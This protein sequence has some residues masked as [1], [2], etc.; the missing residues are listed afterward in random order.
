[1]LCSEL[2]QGLFKLV[3]LNLVVADALCILF[4]LLLHAHLQHLE[5]A[6]PFDR[7]TGTAGL[8]PGST[9]LAPTVGGSL[10]DF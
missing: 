5:L 8:I 9:A 1:M 3:T 10:P 7:A 4:Q 2:P 6:G